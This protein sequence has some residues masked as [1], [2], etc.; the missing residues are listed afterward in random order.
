VSVQSNKGETIKIS[1]I[2]IKGDK[3]TA[4]LAKVGGRCPNV[5]GQTFA[6][7]GDSSGQQKKFSFG[8][9][10]SVGQFTFRQP[11]V[12]NEVTDSGQTVQAQTVSGLSGLGFTGGILMRLGLRGPLAL[13]LGTG[14]LS[15]KTSGKTTLSN[16][17]SYTVTG[18]FME[19]MAQPALVVTRCLSV[20]LFCRVGGVFGFPMGSKL[21]VKTST[22]TNAASLKYMRMGTDLSLGVNLGKHLVVTGGTQISQDKGS[23]AFKDAQDSSAPPETINI[24]VL[25]VYIFGGLTVVF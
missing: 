7:D 20:Q 19:I 12:P 14:A 24:S 16:N 15:A 5:S 9:M 4:K 22:Y 2:R 17:E 3:A 10:G 1:L 11:F 25:T 13:E 6:L 23:F 21:E 18:S 8:V